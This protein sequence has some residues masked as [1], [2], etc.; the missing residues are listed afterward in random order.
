MGKVIPLRPEIEGN[1]EAVP[2]SDSALLVTLTV[3]QLRELIREE[4]RAAIGPDGS[5]TLDALLNAEQVAKILGV[6]PAYV[7]SQARVK[8]IP[9]IKIGKYRKFS[10]SQIKKW[11]DRRN[12]S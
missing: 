3:E 6:E 12:I 9:S 7:Y 5:A 10:P 1:P 2:I 8:K 4:I 11:L